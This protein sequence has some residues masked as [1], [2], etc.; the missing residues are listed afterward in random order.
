[1]FAPFTTRSKLLSTQT[2]QIKLLL[3]EKNLKKESGIASEV[4][5]GVEV[6]KQE[7]MAHG[8]S[9]KRRDRVEG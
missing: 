9:E 1:V 2:E 7:G 8:E 6:L 5:N 4:I 3:E